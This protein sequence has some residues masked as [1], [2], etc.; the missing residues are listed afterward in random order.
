MNVNSLVWVKNPDFKDPFM[1]NLWIPSVITEKVS[2][3]S[4][5]LDALVL[6]L[7]LSQQQMTK[8]MDSVALTV[9]IGKNKETIFK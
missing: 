8:A 7:L 6:K 2:D 3:R 9:K 4:S 5:F 1:D